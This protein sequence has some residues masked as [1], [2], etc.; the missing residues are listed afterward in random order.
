MIVID[1]SVLVAALVDDGPLGIQARAALRQDRHWAAPAHLAIE[2][3]AAIRG[4]VLGHK[5]APRRAAEA[6]DAIGE[7]VLDQVDLTRLVG[8][9]WELRSNL[10]AYDAAYV[11]TAEALDCP[12][13]TADNRL[14][15]AGGVACEMRLVTDR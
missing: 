3:V 14:A 9:V 7:L 8:R 6:V 12:L 10:S 5:V 15:R 1:A 11:A 13:V 2:V 4:L